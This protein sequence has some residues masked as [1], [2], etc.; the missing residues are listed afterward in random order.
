L[1]GGAAVPRRGFG[2]I[3][4]DLLAAI[5]ESPSRVPQR[6]ERVL[7]VRIS[8][9]G[10]A[11]EPP[12]RFGEILRYAF[13]DHE[14]RAHHELR[15]GRAILCETTKHWQCRPVVTTLIRRK[16]IFQIVR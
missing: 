10:R 4:S 1:I 8:L 11:Q 3:L 5:L 12:R 7:R 6:T 9:L 14:H 2:V 16:G 15:H 13:P